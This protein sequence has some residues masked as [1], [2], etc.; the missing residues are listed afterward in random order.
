MQVIHDEMA[1]RKAL[2]GEPKV[3]LVPT[4]GNLH[5]G[6][7]SLIELA[8]TSSAKVV[9]SIYVNPL[10]FG[11]QEDFKRYPRTLEQDLAL[12]QQAGV[13]IVFAPNDETMYPAFDYEQ[14]RTGQDVIIQ[15]PPVADR[16]CGAHRKGHFNGVATVVLKLFNMTLSNGCQEAYAVFGKKDY[17]QL[18]LIQH[19]IKQLNLPIRLLAQETYR[20]EDG[21]ALS[22]RNGYL[23][24]EERQ[25]ANQL[26]KTLEGLAL[27]IDQNTNLR[28]LEKAGAEWLTEQ[29]WQVDYVEICNRATLL[30][31][32]KD[33]QELVILAAAYLGKT[34]LIDNLEHQRTRA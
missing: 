13:D 8:Q 15:L 16:L 3:A 11:P 6:H 17:Q 19:M 9:A 14:Q 28:Q 20:A 33:D 24:E 18:W 23:S 10:Q 29:G 32:E 2:Q 22:S 25:Q 31:A 30:P 12:L 4:M 21:L 5:Q 26:H 7:L 1:L 34:R 27:L